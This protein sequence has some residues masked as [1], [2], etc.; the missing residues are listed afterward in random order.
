MKDTLGNQLVW[1]QKEAMKEIEKQVSVA[2]REAAEIL[3]KQVRANLQKG[4]DFPKARRGESGLLGTVKV[5]K[6][7]YRDEMHMVGV[8]DDGGGE[9]EK[10]MGAQAVFVE[11]GHAKPGDKGGPK[12]VPAKPFF[13]PAIKSAKR[14]IYNKFKDGVK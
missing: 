3:K 4:G 2:S 9:W 10:T 8:F 6:S 13:R 5:M 11:F 14:K 7:K 12:H 1:F